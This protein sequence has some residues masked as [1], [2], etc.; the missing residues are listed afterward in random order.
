MSNVPRSKVLDF[1]ELV[2]EILARPGP[3]RLVAVDGPGG[4]GKSTFAARL[5]RWAGDAPVIHTDD[6]ASWEEPLN[7]WPRLLAQV[8][9]PLG[10]GEPARYQRYDWVDRE[11]AEWHTVQPVPIVIIEGV[12][13][14]RREWSD[15][16]AFVCWMETDR[17]VRLRRGLDRDGAEA[18]PLWDEWMANEDRHFAGDDSRAR[19]DV[20]ADGNPTD[21][22]DAEVAFVVLRRRAV[23][24]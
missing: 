15:R 14:A 1:A 22:H 10:A 17:G 2:G 19:A 12:S 4:A 16:L 21:A 8:I 18:L 7:W 20:V 5:A 13:S 11:L 6:F 23:S 9:A 24:S 3:V